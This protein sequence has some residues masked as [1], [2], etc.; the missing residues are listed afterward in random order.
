MSQQY[1]HVST[2]YRIHKFRYTCTLPSYF[3]GVLRLRESCVSQ[4]GLPGTLVFLRVLLG[5]PR[6]IVEC[7]ICVYVCMCV[8]IYIYIYIYI[9]RER[10]RERESSFLQINIF[11]TTI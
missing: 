8:C 2:A 3:L 9:Y 11:L 6:E 5:V 1:P 4:A 10:E 7:E